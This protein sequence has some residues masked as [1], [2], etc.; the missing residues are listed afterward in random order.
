VEHHA[1]AAHVP[2]NRPER[3]Q[4]PRAEDDAVP[5][6]RHDEEI[7]RERGALDGEGGVTDDHDAGDPLAVGDHGGEA[8]PLVNRQSCAPCR[9]FGDEVM[10][11]AGVEEG[12][13]RGGTERDCDLHGVSHGH[14]GEG[15]QGA[16]PSA[17][18]VA[19]S[20]SLISTPSMKKMRLQNRLWPHEY[21]SL[22]LQHSP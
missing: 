9:C 11:A 15:L 14:P 8:W 5:G 22:Q 4:P 3:A 10:G 18:W 1:T 17:P 20:A 21:F 12:D 19:S 16:S 13:Q 6:Q 2:H 7:G